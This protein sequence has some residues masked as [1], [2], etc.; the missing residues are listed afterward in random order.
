MK[1]VNFEPKTDLNEYYNN[2]YNIA[3]VKDI[4]IDWWYTL[5]LLGVDRTKIPDYNKMERRSILDIEALDFLNLLY[6]MLETA[7]VN[8]DTPNLF[9]EKLKDEIDDELDE[10]DK[11]YF[12]YRL[13]ELIEA[14]ANT[15]KGKKK[16]Q[17]ITCSQKIYELF[18]SIVVIDEEDYIEH[19]RPS[20]N[21]LPSPVFDDEDV[22]EYDFK[23]VKKHLATLNSIKDKI[24]YLEEVK[25][26]FLQEEQGYLDL[27]E[28]DFAKKCQLE[29]DK[30][31]RLL[32]LETN[33]PMNLQS[34]FKLSGSKYATKINVIKILHAIYELKMFVNV[35]NEELPKKG[36]FMEKVGT[37]F[38]LDL[39]KYNKNLTVH[40][41]TTKEDDTLTE[42]FDAMK[43]IILERND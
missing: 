37:F 12:L 22:E 10:K 15:R 1:E 21:T 35:S 17:L 19:I 40:F 11:K 18:N 5:F 29:I 7:K 4:T 25:T 9:I 8:K 34:S 42:I 27:D 36:E 20:F 3:L 32:T 41:G 26:E 39:T 38:G 28:Q 16:A 6:K 23:E 31:Q 30:L 14:Y 24:I 33:I 43:N 2:E 13:S